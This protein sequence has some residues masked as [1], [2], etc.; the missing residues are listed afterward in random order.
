MDID[1]V[2]L[3]REAQSHPGSACCQALL[4]VLEASIS[5]PVPVFWVLRELGLKT[6]D[7]RQSRQR[8]IPIYL[9]PK[10]LRQGERNRAG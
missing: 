6:V 7:E 5:S 10:P 9:A 2:S 8:K 4:R 1:D 3:G